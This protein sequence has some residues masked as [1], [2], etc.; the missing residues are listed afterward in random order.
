MHFSWTAFSFSLIFRTVGNKLFHAGVFYNSYN[1]NI[2]INSVNK[3]EPIATNAKVN[4]FE[5]NIFLKLHYY[6]DSHLD[7]QNTTLAL[8]KAS[9]NY[10]GNIW[11]NVV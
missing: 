3:K 2:V 11:A 10:F 9:T 8:K 4:L 7:L 1:S 6:V 5:M